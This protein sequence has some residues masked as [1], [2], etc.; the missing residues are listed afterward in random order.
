MTI[1]YLLELLDGSF[2]TGKIWSYIPYRG[3]TTP[4]MLFKYFVISVRYPRIVFI[5]F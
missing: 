4:S 5:T 3:K 2:G 1:L